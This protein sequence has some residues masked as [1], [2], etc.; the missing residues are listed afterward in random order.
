ML[1]LFRP[2]L[3]EYR[4]P[5]QLRALI[6]GSEPYLLIDVRTR[7][8]YEDGCIPTAVCIPHDEVVASIPTED[9]DMLIV[10]YC[11]S[12]VRSRD[13]R[14]ALRRAGFRRVHDFGGIIHWPDALVLPDGTGRPPGE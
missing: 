14:K 10:L 2:E 12:G 9:R 3:P 6:D 11:Y 8:E 13:A 4:D 5:D 1:R 7:E